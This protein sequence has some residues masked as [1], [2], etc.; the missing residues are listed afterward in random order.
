MRTL[1]KIC[2]RQAILPKQLAIPLCYNPTEI[3][4]CKGGF[5]DVWKGQYNGRDVAS[6]VLRVYQTS[7]LKQIRKV[8]RSS[9]V[10]HIDELTAHCVEVL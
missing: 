7:D 2:G 5:A 4:L 9:P 3:P 1:Y 6:K 10:A 8:G